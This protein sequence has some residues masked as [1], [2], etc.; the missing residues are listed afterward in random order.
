MCR[1]ARQQFHR[2]GQHNDAL[3]VLDFPALDFAIFRFVIGAGKKALDRAQ[4]RS[5]VGVSHH[6]IGIKTSFHRQS[7]PNPLD[8]GS[9]IDEDAVQIKKKASDRG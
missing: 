6:R 3:H 7:S 5:A 9:G 1:Q 4:T 2:A 8:S